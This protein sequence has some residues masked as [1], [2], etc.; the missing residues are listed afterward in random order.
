MYCVCILLFLLSISPVYSGESGEDSLPKS[1]YIRVDDPLYEPFIERYI[2]DELRSLRNEQEQFKAVVSEKVAHA[3]IDATDRS[4]KYTTDTVNN[5]FFIITAAGSLLVIIGWRSL[6][7]IKQKVEKIVENKI[8]DITDRYQERLNILE[9]KA[10]KRADQIID[11]QEEISRTNTIHS[12]WMRANLDTNPQNKITILDEIIELNPNDVEATTHKAE[13]VLELGESEWALNLSNTAIK[14]D[15]DYGYAY[16]QRGCSYAE[17]G[18]KDNAL[19]DIK[20]ALDKSPD[21]RTELL[22][23]KSFNSLRDEPEF[24]EIVQSHD[25]DQ[26]GAS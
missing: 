13:A 12:L 17:L 18:D 2:L 3:R 16:W 23:E 7:D 1:G 22:N 4:V 26:Q 6:N 19:A 5:I 11:A 8:T 21:L 10:Q 25:P 9:A 24:Q 14:Y 20:A 15:A